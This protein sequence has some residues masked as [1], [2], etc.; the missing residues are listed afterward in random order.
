MSNTSEIR[1][2]LEL[3]NVIQRRSVGQFCPE[4]PPPPKPPRGWLIF[5]IILSIILA[6]IV[7]V[8]LY[9]YFT[10][11]SS[12]ISNTTTPASLGGSCT[13][14]PCAS[15]LNCE[16]GICKN[17]V[18]KGPCTASNCTGG[19]TCDI[20]SSTCKS[21]YGGICSINSDCLDSNLICTN[22]TC[23]FPLGCSADSD[24]AT[25]GGP[26]AYCG[27]GNI[28]T[29]VTLNGLGE[30]CNNT[31]ISCFPPYACLAGTCV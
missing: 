23:S 13:S 21:S 6:I 31:S 11:S 3:P 20:I 9:L 22:G 8:L 10:K 15:G 1:E 2:P 16:A 26:Q 25:T 24:C 28:C 7:I 30:S 12:S 19:T 4:P 17:A 29:T 14:N 27:A 5:L 18:G